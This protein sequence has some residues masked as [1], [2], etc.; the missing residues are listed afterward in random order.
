M[1]SASFGRSSDLS[2]PYISANRNASSTTS[3]TTLGSSTSLGTEWQLASCPTSVSSNTTA[4]LHQYN[5]S[6]YRQ[7]SDSTVE[8]STEGISSSIPLSVITNLTVPSSANGVTTANSNSLTGTETSVGD[9]RDRR[10]SYLT[11]VRDE[12]AESLRKA[13]SR[14]ARQTRRSTQGVTLTDLQ[15]AE[16]T[17]SRSR[18][19]RQTQE[20]PSEKSERIEATAEGSE[21]Q[22]DTTREPRETRSRWS[23]NVDE[24]PVGRRL[25]C[26]AQEDKPTTPTSPSLAPYLYSSSHL[27]RTS[28]CLSSDTVNPTDFQSTSTDNMEKNDHED[29]DLDDKNSNKQSVRER[30]RP[31]ERRRGTGI[32]FFTKEDEEMDGIEE[33][34]DDRKA[35]P[36]C[37]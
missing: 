35:P 1:K 16:R 27:P 34:K 7:Q 33:A 3:S 13:R 24:E 10:R 14:Q 18:A 17:F 2:S 9:A 29:Q 20:Q 25:R 30:R 8:K 28:R 5:R 26:S 22:E 12:E 37:T 19:E 31:K 11:P 6:P 36:S 15:E 23:R 4:S 32:S 21:K